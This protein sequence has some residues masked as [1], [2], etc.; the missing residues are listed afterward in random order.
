MTPFG[1]VHT[2]IS[3][4]AL[5]AGAVA[6]IRDKQIS[7]TNRVGQL[8]IGGTALSAATGLFIFHHGGFGK[9]HALS[10]LTLLVLGV[11]GLARATNV[12]G[13]ASRYVETVGYSAT[14]FFS[15]IPGITETATR[16]P[17]NAP[18]V[19]GPDAPELQL[20][21]GLLFAAFLVGAT[22]QV[23]RLRGSRPTVAR[24][25]A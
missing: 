11:A 23:L 17:K 1:I 6:L 5:V 15:T 7:I 16:L 21:V 24:V 9:P 20:A 13:R 14:F 19:S 18:L 12:F 25:A 10:I 8:Y 4:F 22:I 2:I 3:V